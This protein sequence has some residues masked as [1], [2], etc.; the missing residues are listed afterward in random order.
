MRKILLVLAIWLLSSS[1]VFG[2]GFRSRHGHGASVQVTHVH[3]H[4]CGHVFV[5]GGW[6]VVR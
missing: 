6:I 3:G 5:N 1:C 4:R 2:V